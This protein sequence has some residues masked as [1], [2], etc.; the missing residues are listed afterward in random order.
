MASLLLHHVRP[1][2]FRGR[3]RLG[4]LRA[5]ARGLP[6]PPAA[7]RARTRPAPVDIRVDDGVV[8]EVGPDLEPGGEPVLDVEGAFVVPG[9]WDAHAH[10]DLEAA[11]RSRIDTTGTRCAED[12]LALVAD[13]VAA[14]PADGSGPAAPTVQG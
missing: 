12:A 6:G 8:T 3:R 4:R 2:R 11:R 14:L 5:A 1:V 7:E 9:L 10:L 13:A